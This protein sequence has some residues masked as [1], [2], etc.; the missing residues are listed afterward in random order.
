[1]KKLFLSFGVLSVVLTSCDKVDKPYPQVQST[2]LDETLYPGTW[3]NYVANEWPQFTQNTNQNKNVLVEDYTGHKCTFCPAAAVIAHDLEQSNE[4]RIF[5]ASIH[6]SNNGMSSFQTLEPPNYVHDFT[7]PQGLEIGTFFGTYDGGFPGNP[8]GTVNRQKSGGV[9]F[10]TPNLW[11]NLANSILTA[12]D[13]D[14]NLQAKSNYYAA[15]RGLFLHTEIEKIDNTIANDI[16]VVVYLIEDSLVADQK[17]GDN[18]HNAT[19]IHRDIHRG[20]IDGRA[21]GRT[22]TAADL[23]ENGRYYL[24]YSYKLPAQYVPENMHLLVY[25]YNKETYEIYQV[26]KVEFAE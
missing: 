18:S 13:L 1:M 5:I 8:R 14:V 17:M 15:T 11:T 7:N 16:G 9:I 19:Y 12:N 3:S 2:E 6:S 21:F 23:K 24:N 10:L 4:E 26:V 22:L 25:A 20:N